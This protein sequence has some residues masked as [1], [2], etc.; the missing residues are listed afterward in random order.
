MNA[1]EWQKRYLE[2]VQ[3]YQES[4]SKVRQKIRVITSD[5]EQDKE[6]Q[7]EN[8]D[9]YYR[10]FQKVHECMLRSSI[11]LFEYH[12]Q[13]KDPINADNLSKQLQRDTILLRSFE[14]HLIALPSIRN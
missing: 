5:I 14:H 10:E 11:E 6:I 2:L 4:Y 1:I 7:P 9:E 12:Q 13:L 8:V 3:S